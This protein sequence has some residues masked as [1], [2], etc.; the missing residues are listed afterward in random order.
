MTANY[1]PRV[2]DVELERRLKSVG[3]IVIEGAKWCGKST[4]AE[5]HSRSQVFMDNPQRREQYQLFAEENPS[6]I[7]NGETPR[8]IDEW[9]LAPRLW[10]AV[11]YTIDHRPGMGQFLLTG[12]AKPA[13]RQQ[14]YHSGT[15]RFAWVKIPVAQSAFLNSLLPR[16]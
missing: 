12:S 9:Q 16:T 7:L 11:R 2:L 10:D 5:Y 14:I 3:A 4:T 8:L 6:M 13:D 15:G 1:R